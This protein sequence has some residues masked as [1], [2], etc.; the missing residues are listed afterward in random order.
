VSIPAPNAMIE[1]RRASSDGGMEAL[2]IL[3]HRLS[4]VVYQALRA[5]LAVNANQHTA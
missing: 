1:R 2:R 3:K 5:D 4:D